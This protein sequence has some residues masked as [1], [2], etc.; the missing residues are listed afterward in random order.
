ML[1]WLREQLAPIASWTAAWTAVGAVIGLATAVRGPGSFGQ[2]LLTAAPFSALY[3]GV[4]GFFCALF[5]HG[6]AL[7]GRPPRHVSA[8]TTGLYGAAVGVLPVLSF[9]LDA[10]SRGITLEN[11]VRDGIAVAALGAATALYLRWRDA[12][13]QRAWGQLTG[14]SSPS[15]DEMLRRESVSRGQPTAS[16]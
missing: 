5:Y 16:R 8:R 3:L 9:A 2:D 1:T 13:S 12:R 10:A 4:T 15:V 14:P 11:G 6:F 7:R